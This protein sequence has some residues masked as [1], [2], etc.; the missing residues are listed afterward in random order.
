[1]SVDDILVDKDVYG[2]G[3]GVVELIEEEVVENIGKVE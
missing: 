3:I 2:R 1:V